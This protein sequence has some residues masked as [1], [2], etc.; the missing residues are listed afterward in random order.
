MKQG[1]TNALIEEEKIVVLDQAWN[2]VIQMHKTL[3]FLLS[4]NQ[5]FI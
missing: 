5:D 4:Q 2:Y 3:T 1:K